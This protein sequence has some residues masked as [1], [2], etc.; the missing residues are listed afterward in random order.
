MRQALSSQTVVMRVKL[1]LRGA[2]FWFKEAR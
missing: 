1:D 2:S